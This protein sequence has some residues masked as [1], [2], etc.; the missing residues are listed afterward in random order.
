MANT[1]YEGKKYVFLIDP[2]NT[3]P[4]DMGVA[5]SLVVCLTENSYTRSASVI[6]ASSKC[7]TYQLNGPKTRTIDLSGQVIFAPDGT[8][9]SEGELNDLFENDTRFSW[10][11][12]P[13]TPESG[14]QYYTGADA[15]I[16]DLVLTAPNDGVVEFTATVQVNGVPVRHTEGS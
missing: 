14:D 15:V 11:H 10:L 16:S 3:E 4:S 1:P 9:M 12:G 8:A 6:D 13:E 7:G 2:T 5:P